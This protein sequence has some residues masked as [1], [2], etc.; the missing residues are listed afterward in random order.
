MAPGPP[1]RSRLLL[2]NAII[3]PNEIHGKT[4]LCTP[5]GTSI[6]CPPVLMTPLRLGKGMDHEILKGDNHIHW[7]KSPNRHKRSRNGLTI[8]IL[9]EN[10]LRQVKTHPVFVGYD[11]TGE[12]TDVLK[13]RDVSSILVQPPND[14]IIH[15]QINEAYV[16]YMIRISPGGGG[17]F[18][19][20]VSGQHARSP[21]KASSE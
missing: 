8:A 12:P 5:S 3:R 20:A 14:I 13:R 16:V 15:H 1:P 11:P 6:V 17:G 18:H 21:S 19:L 9:L 10:P 4:I 7:I 2:D